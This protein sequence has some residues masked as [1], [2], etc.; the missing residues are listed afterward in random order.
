MDNI[1]FVAVDNDTVGITLTSD[2]NSTS[3][4]GDSGSFSV[5]LN[6]QPTDN[7]SLFFVDNDTSGKSLGIRFVP[8]NLSFDN[9]SDNWSSA[10]TV[11]GYAWNDSVDEGSAGPDNQSFL[12][13][14][15]RW[16]GPL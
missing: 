8:D 3:E 12:E 9:S 1:T 14:A 4:N 15:F 11:M 2:D 7:V 16:K 13:T 6:S 5:R 10:Q